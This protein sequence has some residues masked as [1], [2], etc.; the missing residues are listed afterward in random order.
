MLLERSGFFYAAILLY[1]VILGIVAATTPITPSE[2][3]RF[4]HTSDIS[5]FLMHVGYTKIPSELGLRIFFILFG[6]LNAF[7]Y[8]QITQFF[9]QRRTDQ[10][11][12]TLIYLLFPG[13]V[14][15]SILANSAI[16]VS[17]LILSFLYAF[18]IRCWAA[19]FVAL[20]GLALVHWSAVVIYFILALYAVIQRE[21][22]LIGILIF[23]SLFWIRFGMAFPLPAEGNHLLELLSV[24]AAVF[25][26]LIFIYLFYTLYRILLRGERGMIWYLSFFSLVISLLMSLRYRISIVDFSPYMMLGSMLMIQGYYSSLRVRMRRFQRSYRWVFKIVTIFLMLSTLSILLNQ[27]IYRTVGNEYFSVFS[28]VYRPYNRAL[29]LKS[30]GKNC[31]EEIAGKR[32]EQMKF[33]GI[34]KCF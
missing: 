20:I 7:L 6:V 26:P 8:Y 32:L 5:T 1:F 33:Y 10:Y 16:I 17:T 9:I 23:A 29:K 18:S 2:A 34:D 31:I 3:Y 27:P 15:S 13:V 21:K 28:P 14:A 4:Y 30:N 12:S 24:Y 22:L 19:V 25:S 11:L